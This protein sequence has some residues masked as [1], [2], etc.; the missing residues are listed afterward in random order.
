MARAL[1]Q[2]VYRGLS[3]R[4]AL[5]RRA[6]ETGFRKG[7]QKRLG[8]GQ[9]FGARD[10][11]QGP[12]ALLGRFLASRPRE[13]R[14]S[15]KAVQATPR[16]EITIRHEAQFGRAPFPLCANPKRPT[17]G[18][19]LRIAGKPRRRWRLGSSSNL[20]GDLRRFSAL[21]TPLLTSQ[22]KQA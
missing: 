14:R 16:E 17:R 2:S 5:R 12:K 9:R 4:R 6:Q 18:S 8:P 15:S 3:N 22:P 11:R 1:G 7:Q 21:L 19:R 13:G 20:R 10:L